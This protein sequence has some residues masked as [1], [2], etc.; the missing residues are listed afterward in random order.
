[1]NTLEFIK[2]STGTQKSPKGVKRDC[3]LQE[4]ESHKIIKLEAIK[5]MQRNW[6]RHYKCCPSLCEFIQA[7]IILS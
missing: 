2:T 5:V 7:L 3:H 6:Y 4:Y 1:M